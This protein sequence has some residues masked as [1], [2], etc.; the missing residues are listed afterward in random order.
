MAEIQLQLASLKP[1]ALPDL[2]KAAEFMTGF[3]Q[4]YGI[5]SQ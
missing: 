1:A 3:G 5:A 2:S 4:L